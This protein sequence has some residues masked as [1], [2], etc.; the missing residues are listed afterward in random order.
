LTKA[1]TLP[2]EP[3]EDHYEHLAAAFL[4]ADGYFV[5]K[6]IGERVERRDF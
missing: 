4:A 2:A 5:N 1:V 3:T 6:N